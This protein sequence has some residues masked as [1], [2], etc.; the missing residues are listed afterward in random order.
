MKTL[1]LGSNI[2]RN[3]RDA[4]KRES[5]TRKTSAK[6]P[7]VVE[8]V[9]QSSR[10]KVRIEVDKRMYLV[11]FLLSGVQSLRGDDLN[12][13]ERTV[14]KK[15]NEWVRRTVQQRDQVF[16]EIE[17]LDKNSNFV[18]YMFFKDGRSTINVSQEL[19][20][21][22]WAKVF[23]NS[24]DRSKYGR[25]M[26]RVEEDSKNNQ[27]GLWHDF[28]ETKD[29]EVAIAVPNKGDP[30]QAS[31]APAV[32]RKH[33]LQDQKITANVTYVESATELCVVFTGE[34]YER[35]YNR[36]TNYMNTVN[37]SRN[38][39]QPDSTFKTGD[40]A[41]GLFEGKYYRSL[42]CRDHFFLQSYALLLFCLM[43]RE[44]RL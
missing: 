17:A 20:R 33:P 11:I 31:M 32:P 7:A 42:R 9:F 5:G 12:E 1:G 22:G 13:K 10:M 6:I 3:R 19:L 37:P 39:I 2:D 44:Q 21:N 18:G 34:A 4:G 38:I 28:L 29:S 27:R 43:L 40:L 30:A 35:D 36:V 25:M 23:R 24:A 14:Q 41:A 16:V 8:Y 26:H 15:A